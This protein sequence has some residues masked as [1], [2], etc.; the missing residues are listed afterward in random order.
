MK[1]LQ[2]VLLVIISLILCGCSNTDHLDLYLTATYS[3]PGPA[4]DQAATLRTS[5]IKDIETDD[6]GR[7]MC[8]VWI[9]RLNFYYI[10]GG[11]NKEGF[12]I[13]TKV[14]IILQHSDETHIYYYEDACFLFGSAD[15]FTAESIEQ[16]KKRN[17]W[18]QPLIIEKCSAASSNKIYDGM[19]HIKWNNAS[20]TLIK[21]TFDSIVEWLPV[22][23]DQNGKE[24]YGVYTYDKA[25]DLFQSYFVIVDPQN[26]IDPNHGVM[27]LT[28]L[29]FGEELHNFKIQN[30]WTF[31]CDKTNY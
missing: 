16:L 9:P 17:D 8:T 26:G 27:K 14:K 21:K 30:H 23:E 10:N 7:Q 25:N 5:I 28:S 2:L 6:Y 31:A 4:E 13:P 18:N 29:D 3:F 22:M 1:R 12:F 24:L 20:I 19:D 11:T 15:G